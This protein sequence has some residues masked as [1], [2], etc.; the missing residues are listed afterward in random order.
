LVGSEGVTSYALPATG[1]VNAVP[2]IQQS[3]PFADEPFVDFDWA[4]NLDM[5]DWPM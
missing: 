2:D 5:T 4:M 3:A 1:D